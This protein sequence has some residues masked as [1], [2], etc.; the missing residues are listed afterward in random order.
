MNYHLLIQLTIVCYVI[1]IVYAF[2]FVFPATI[3]VSVMKSRLDL[4]DENSIINS[5]LWK[6]S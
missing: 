2:I 3:I 1:K 5:E 6:K 4:K